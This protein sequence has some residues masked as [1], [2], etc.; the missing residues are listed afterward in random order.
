[1]EKKYSLK[2]E[3][4]K[5]VSV[6]IDGVRYKD[7]N[8]IPDPQDR[9]TIRLLM[10]NPPDGESAVPGS[11]STSPR[12]K[13]LTLIFLAVALLMI[14][15]AGLTAVNTMAALSR[16]ESAQGY[17]V[18]L[19]VRDDDQG[20]PFYYP[21]VEYTLPNGGKKTVQLAEGSWPPAYDIG[22]A[23]N[24]LYD[25]EQPLNAHIKTGSSMLGWFT[26]SIITGILGIAFVVATLVSH[27][28]LSV[29]PDPPEEE[30]TRF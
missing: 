2:W 25:P 29:V 23:I 6:E 8:L 21:L 19:I 3:N 14:I 18:D 22:Q 20:Q 30:D 9:A 15:I 28:I 16:Q 17:V 5:V 7:P 13:P 10:S 11:D 12:V 1:M 26:W 27:W 24:I 4:G